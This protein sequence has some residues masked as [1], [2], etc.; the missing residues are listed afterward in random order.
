MTGRELVE[1]YIENPS[2][3]AA[4]ISDITLP[5]MNAYEATEKIRRFEEMS[6]IR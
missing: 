5:I 2:K 1:V 6:G 4:V 3:F